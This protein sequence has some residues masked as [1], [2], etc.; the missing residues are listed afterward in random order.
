MNGRAASTVLKI[1]HHHP[2]R[3]R[4][5]AEAFI[6]VT[7]LADA[8]RTALVCSGGVRSV[9]HDPRTGSVLVEYEPH[10][11]DASELVERIAGLTGLEPAP[12]EPPRAEPGS[13]LIS[14]VRRLDTIAHEL[15]RGRFDLGVL[16]PGGLAALSVYSLLKGPHKRL[17]RWDSLVYW[18]YTIFR[19]AHASPPRAVP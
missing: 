7:P 4:V 13:G 8:T 15:T 14:L 10:R 1:V 11:I 16:V 6:D 2:G 19:D 17:P 18:G 9:S 5:R 3:L 12:L